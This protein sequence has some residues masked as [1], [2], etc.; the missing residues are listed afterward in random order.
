M[1]GPRFWLEIIFRHFDA[2]RVERVE[3]KLGI[4]ANIFAKLEVKGRGGGVNS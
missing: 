3:T 1:D 4:F 2:K